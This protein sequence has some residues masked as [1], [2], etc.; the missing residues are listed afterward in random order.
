MSQS[1]VQGKASMVGAHGLQQCWV[2]VV[3][4]GGLTVQ[5][6]AWTTRVL[7]NTRLGAHNKHMEVLSSS[8]TAD[9]LPTK[10]GY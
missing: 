9:S 8:N 7:S 10:R 3:R 4:Q 2:K 1:T 6:G 5:L